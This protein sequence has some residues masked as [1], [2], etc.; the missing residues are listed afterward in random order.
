MNFESMYM[1]LQRP[2]P[3]SMPLLR[4]AFL[5]LLFVGGFAMVFV[6]DLADRIESHG[7]QALSGLGPVKAALLL[8]GGLAAIY[9][10]VRH[11]EITLALFFPDRVDQGG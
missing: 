8:V 10:L 7:M 2:W 3:R 5:V 1:Q 9:L 11:A 4:G 6:A